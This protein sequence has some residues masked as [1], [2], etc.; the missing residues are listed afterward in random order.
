MAD[1][2]LASTLAG[3]RAIEQA[4]TPGE[5]KHRTAQTRGDWTSG[6]KV[7]PIERVEADA[8]PGGIGIFDAPADAEFI[9]TART[10]VPSLLAAI[11]AV[12]V[13]HQPKTLYGL[14]FGGLNFDKPL[15]AH[16]PDSDHDAHFEGDDGLW[17]CSGM[18]TG[19]A[20]ITCAELE[21]ADLWAKWPC[22][23]C[24]AITTAL[25]GKEAGDEKAGT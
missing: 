2:D 12:T 24:L 14:A 15:C 9:A 4:A 10:F 22:P 20:C 3:I 11:E 6:S 18:I 5:W 13:L 25:T 17:Y 21:D 16:D 8:R 23:T 7:M 1:A 19:R